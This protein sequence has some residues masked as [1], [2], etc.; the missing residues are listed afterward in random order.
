MLTPQAFQDLPINQASARL[1]KEILEKIDEFIPEITV[2]DLTVQADTAA[3]APHKRWSMWFNSMIR[4]EPY[5]C[6]NVVG[7]V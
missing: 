2:T 5:Q 7:Q 3:G 4:V 1:K 6:L